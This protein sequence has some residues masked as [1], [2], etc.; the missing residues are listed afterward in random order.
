MISKFIAVIVIASILAGSAQL[1]ESEEVDTG[2]AKQ[3]VDWA[4]RPHIQRIGKNLAGNPSFQGADDWLY[5][6]AGEYDK[7]QS[8]YDETVSRTTGSGS[9]KLT[10]AWTGEDGKSDNIRSS[11]PIPI[12]PGMTYTFAVYI[13]TESWPPPVAYLYASYVKE[14]GE[15]VRNISHGGGRWSNTN[16]TGWEECVTFLTPESGDQYIQ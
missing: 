1:I 9:V 2:E 13:K 10:N 14:S 6:L 15:W 12:K 5:Y 11:A 3:A 7:G 8:L 4:T 16:T